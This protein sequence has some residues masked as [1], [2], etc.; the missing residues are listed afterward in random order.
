VPT[1]V[2][3]GTADPLVPIATNGD[4]FIA[5]ING[6]EHA[7]FFSNR[8]EARVKVTDFL[9]RHSTREA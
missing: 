3:H 4:R 5:E 2:V 6:G 1:L 8:D 7:A 9:R